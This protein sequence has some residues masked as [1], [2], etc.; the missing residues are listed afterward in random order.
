MAKV[1]YTAHAKEKLRRLT[2]IGVSEDM[3]LSCLLKPGKVEQ[4][5]FG[6]NI[7]QITLN[8]RLLL[9]VVYE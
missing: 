7:V 4:G 6:R 8:D 1:F 9:R 5:Y 3:V 2:S